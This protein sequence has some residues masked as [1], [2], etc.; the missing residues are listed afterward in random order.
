MHILV[1]ARSDRNADGLAR[2]SAASKGTAHAGLS[3]VFRVFRGR[4]TEHT[5]Y[6]EMNG[7][8]REPEDIFARVAEPAFSYLC[9]RNSE[10]HEKKRPH[11]K[12]QRRKE[13]GQAPILIP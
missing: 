6:T 7:T 3:G 4:S 5:E 8:D 2:H 12:A 1:Q 10:R 11:A 13:S 9:P